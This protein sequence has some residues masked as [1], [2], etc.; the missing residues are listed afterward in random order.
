[1]NVENEQRRS[2]RISSRIRAEIIGR[3]T[4]ETY[5][6]NVSRNGVFLRDKAEHQVNSVVRVR[7][8]LP[9]EK[10]VINVLGRV[11]WR[12]QKDS[13]DGVGIQFL[14]MDTDARKTWLEFVAQVE[15]LDATSRSIHVEEPPEKPAPLPSPPPE[16]ER[17]TTPRTRASFMVRFRSKNRLEHFMTNNLSQGGMFLKTP[18]LRQVGERVQVV[19]I[20]PDTE[21]DFEIEAEVAHIN[22]QTS[23]KGPKGMGLKFVAITPELQQ[24]LAQ[25]IAGKK[26]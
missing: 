15:S 6:V 7:L 21:L 16:P 24:A 22:E 19:I 11:A 4:V 1:M 12:G 13:F 8:F 17:R 3:R 25:F 23:E 9:P 5:T 14:N 10:I 18:V 20:H 26:P 2:D